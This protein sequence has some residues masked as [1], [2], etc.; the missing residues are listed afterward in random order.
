M[1]K[2]K[3]SPP[4]SGD[5]RTPNEIKMERFLSGEF[6]DFVGMV[7]EEMDI[8]VGMVVYWHNKPRKEQGGRLIGIGIHPMIS[9]DKVQLAEFTEYV[10]TLL[11]KCVKDMAQ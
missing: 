6:S 8:T 3:D 7:N 1:S 9:D 5:K 2:Q 11:T 4:L 10:K